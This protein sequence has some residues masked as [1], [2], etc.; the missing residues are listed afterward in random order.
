MG[1]LFDASKPAKLD[2]EKALGHIATFIAQAQPARDPMGRSDS[3][4]YDNAVSAL[5]W[6]EI[7]CDHATEDRTLPI[8]CPHCNGTF[9]LNV[10]GMELSDGR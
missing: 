6:L 1:K 2:L 5:H 10:E 4:E 7:W 8:N 9:N 3:S